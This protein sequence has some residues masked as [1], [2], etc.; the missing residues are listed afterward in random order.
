MAKQGKLIPFRFN[1]AH[2]VVC[3]RRNLTQAWSWRQLTTA[4]AA[5]AAA[6]MLSMMQQSQLARR[7]PWGILIAA[8]LSADVPEP[9]SGVLQW[10]LCAFCGRV[11]PLRQLAQNG[12]LREES[13]STSLCKWCP[14]SFQ[15]INPVHV[16]AA[17]LPMHSIITSYK[18]TA[19]NKNIS[20][21]PT[22]LHFVC[23]PPG[24][25]RRLAK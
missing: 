16:V 13:S 11:V 5:V 23:L 15:G 4:A 18:H 2:S 21:V 25:I 17:N 12:K 20:T 9:L 22:A 7:H 14:F 10:V 3:K 8:M 6:S 1:K 19:A 24:H